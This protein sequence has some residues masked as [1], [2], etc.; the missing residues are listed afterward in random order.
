MK[1]PYMSSTIGSSGRD[2]VLIILFQFYGFKS[3]LFQVGQYDPPQP[4]N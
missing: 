2:S 1:K 3:N 4:S